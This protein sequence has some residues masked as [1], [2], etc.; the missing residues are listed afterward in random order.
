MVYVDELRK[1]FPN[2]RNRKQWKWSTSAHLYADTDGE[3]HTFAAAIGLRR[4]WFQAHARLSH[5][6][7]TAGKRVLA[8]AAGATSHTTK[9]M[10]DFMRSKSA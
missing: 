2:T 1:V 3:L 5:Y 6:D 8:V 10:V 9:E 4:A 7:L